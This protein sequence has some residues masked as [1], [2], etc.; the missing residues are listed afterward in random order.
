MD[1]A[2]IALPDGDVRLEQGG[3]KAITKF[4]GSFALLGISLLSNNSLKRKLNLRLCLLV[5]N[6]QQRV[7]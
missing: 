7:C 4:D 5:T 1:S 2:G 6:L 3:L